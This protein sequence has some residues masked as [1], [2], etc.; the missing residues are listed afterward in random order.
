[1]FMDFGI[2]GHGG[3]MGPGANSLWIP[4]DSLIT[5]QSHNNAE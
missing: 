2:Y 3:N 1:M 4:R 5:C